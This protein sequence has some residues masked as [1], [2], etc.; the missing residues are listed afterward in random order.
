ME[1]KILAISENSMYLLL[2]QLKDLLEQ[3]TLLKN[4]SFLKLCNNVLCLCHDSD[5]KDILKMRFK[6]HD[7][8]LNQ[9]LYKGL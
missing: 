2:A 9:G 4:K 7:I 5:D 8:L 6:I 3:K 1:D